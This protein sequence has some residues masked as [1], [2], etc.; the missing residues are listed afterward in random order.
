MSILASDRETSSMVHSGEREALARLRLS[1]GAQRR[2][3][4]GDRSPTLEERKRRL[5]SLIGMMLG[6]RA[7]IADALHEDFGSHPRPASDLI[8]VLGVVGRAQHVL[9]HLEAWMRP[10]PREVD[11]SLLGASHAYVLSQPKGV[12]GN[13]V[14]WNFPFDLSVGPLVEMLAAGNRAIIKPSE[15][16]PACASLLEEMVAATFDASLVHVAVGGIDL[17]REFPKLAWDHLLY[18]GSQDVGRQVMAA[19]AAN[20]T[21]VTLEL[22]GKCPAV[23]TPGSVS[24]QSVESVIGTKMVKSGQMCVSVDYCFVPK[25]ELATFVDHALSF[26]RRAAP[27]FSQGPDYTGIVSLRHFDR[28]SDLLEEARGHQCKI[29]E[30]EDD[31]IAERAR[32]RMPLSLVVDPALDLRLLQE[33]IFGPILPVVVYDDLEEVIAAINKGERPLGLYVFGSN[34]AAI[35]RLLDATTSGGVAVNTC[36]MQAALPSLGFGGI[37]ASGMGCHHGVAGFR[38]FSNE[39]GV[40]VRGA[41]DMIDAFYPP[42]T[43]AAAIVA[44]ALS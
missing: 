32:R 40:F 6:H 28:L 31:P 1:F 22:G 43:K 3:F 26:V 38:E 16:T 9:E 33:E 11:P 29:I 44:A 42:Y 21:P 8:E 34:Q 25:A 10:S 2:A 30:L 15:F 14:P 17:A 37:G 36:A 27:T 41:G 20:L 39:R 4:S 7:R 24:A 35:D 12:I 18:T 5:E 23:L 19:A 13:M